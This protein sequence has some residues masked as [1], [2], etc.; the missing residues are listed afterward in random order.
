[1]ESRRGTTT[2]VTVVAVIIAVL[3][4]SVYFLQGDS[5]NSLIGSVLPSG[6]QQS[7]AQEQELPASRTEDQAADTSDGQEQGAETQVAQEKCDALGLASQPL[8]SGEECIEVYNA[9]SWVN[10]DGGSTATINERSTTAFVV[11]NTGMKTVTISSIYLRSVPVPVQDWYH[12][13]D[14]VIARPANLQETLP[15]DYKETAVLIGG[16]LAVMQS[17]AITLEPGQAAIVY[18]NEA[19]GLTEKDAGLNI[20]LQVQT[21]NVQVLSPV[22]V[23]AARA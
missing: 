22:T 15:V 4:T 21:A 2:T 10:D 14:P 3:G 18:L 7:S 5:I 1:M 16:S 11:E 13:K 8:E 6:D 23:V 20:V 19:G 9:H 12:T 17:G